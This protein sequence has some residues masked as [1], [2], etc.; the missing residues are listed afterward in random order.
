MYTTTE[1]ENRIEFN[2]N[3]SP[4][5]TRKEIAEETLKDN[6][7]LEELLQQNDT[8]NEKVT[9]RL[10][11]I[12]SE[13]DHAKES[14]EDIGFSLGKELE[15]NGVDEEIIN[16]VEKRLYKDFIDNLEAAIGTLQSEAQ[17]AH[18][19]ILNFED[20]KEGED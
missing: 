16:E 13:A 8:F 11:E 5:P 2:W 19:W 14:I 6:Y 18:H 7:V 4:S 10:A 9:R 12:D 20:P 17:K 15:R 3:L 1:L